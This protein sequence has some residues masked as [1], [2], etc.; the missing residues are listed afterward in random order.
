MQSLLSVFRMSRGDHTVASPCGLDLASRVLLVSHNFPPVAGPESLLVRI[1]AESLRRA[2]WDVTVLTSGFQHIV[3]PMDETLLEALPNELKLVRVSSPEAV[4]AQRFGAWGKRLV[5]M[6]SRLMLPDIHFPWMI[7]ATRRGIRE[8]RD[9][10]PSVIYSRAP[11]HVSNVVGWRL[12]KATGL[13][14]VAHFSDVWMASGF[15]PRP[16][17][18][19]LGRLWE[20]RIVRDADALVFVSQQAADLCMRA[21]PAAWAS[22]VHVIPHGYVSRLAIGADRVGA[23][24]G[25]LKV[26]HAGA[27]YPNIRSPEPLIHGLRLLNTRRELDGRLQVTCVGVD[28][29]EHQAAIEKAGLSGVIQLS[30]AVP[31]TQLQQMIDVSDLILVIDAE[32][33]RGMLPTKLIEGFAFGKPVLGLAEP[34]SAVAETLQSCGLPCADSR[35]PQAIASEFE[36]LLA[37]WEAGQWGLDDAIRERLSAFEIDRVN[38]PLNQLLHSLTSAK[39]SA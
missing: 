4:F 10:K 14:W 6:T 1:N 25:V 23:P 30:P 16:I 24:N 22:R 33:S 39:Q 5:G 8:T 31:F 29:M 20:R 15:H 28:T 17:Q 32:A 35:S 12:K 27:F 18:R 26:I 19:W 36:L 21:Y 38:K 11:K 13:P 34:G 9:W 7:P 37:R 3:Q 2:G